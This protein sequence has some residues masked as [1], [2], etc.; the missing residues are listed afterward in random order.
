MDEIVGYDSSVERIVVHRWV[1]SAEDIPD[2]RY[3]RACGPRQ[4]PRHWRI[5][6]ENIVTQ[7]PYLR[8]RKRCRRCFPESKS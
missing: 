6:P 7:E 1:R 4:P 8:G 3:R 5:C 2:V